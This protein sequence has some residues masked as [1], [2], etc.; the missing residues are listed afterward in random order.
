MWLTRELTD[1]L[2]IYFP[3]LKA[4][5]GRDRRLVVKILRALYGLVQSAAL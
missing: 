4:F 3:E 1:I 2:V 5:V